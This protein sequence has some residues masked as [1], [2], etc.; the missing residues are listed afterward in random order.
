MLEKQKTEAVFKPALKHVDVAEGDGV[1]RFPHSEFLRV[2]SPRDALPVAADSPN[3]AELNKE[4]K[5]ANKSTRDRQGVGDIRHEKGIQ[6]APSACVSGS[7]A[8]AAAQLVRFRDVAG[9]SEQIRGWAGGQ[10][11]GTQHPEHQPGVFGSHPHV[12]NDCESRLKLFRVW[13]SDY[14]AMLID[15]TDKEHAAEQ[16]QA[17]SRHW[18]RLDP[19]RATT[20]TKL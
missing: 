5:Y 4:N 6:D 11:G 13:F 19:R 14:S 9:G 1:V 3:P 12:G 18:D 7:I 10:D 15:A 2:Q 8:S 16:G 20:V 17:W